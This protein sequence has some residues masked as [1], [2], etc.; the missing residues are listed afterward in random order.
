MRSTSH[1]TVSAR[2]CA[3]L[4][5]LGTSAAACADEPN[6]SLIDQRPL[7]MQVTVSDSPGL[8]E[9]QIIVEFFANAAEPLPDEDGVIHF[10]PEDTPDNASF[11]VQMSAHIKLEG[12]DINHLASLSMAPHL[13]KDLTEQQ[14]VNARSSSEPI[15]DSVRTHTPFTYLPSQA[16]YTIA[17][18]RELTGMQLTNLT[19]KS[20]ALNLK[21]GP[22]FEVP[23]RPMA[24]DAAPEAQMTFTGPLTLGCYINR[25]GQSMLDLSWESPFCARVKAEMNLSQYLD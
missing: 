22:V 16:R 10:N 4:F 17:L 3:L 11:I 12:S 9:G 1:T 21:L 6:I 20:V 7:P 14:A 13:W 5:A 2:R 25:G 23:D 15:E 18:D 24:Q 19:K 8:H